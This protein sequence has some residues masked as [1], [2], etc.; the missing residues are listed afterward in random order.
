MEK[1]KNTPKRQILG[2]AYVSVEGIKVT[3]EKEEYTDET[4]MRRKKPSSML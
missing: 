4:E 3:R 2:K 1:Q